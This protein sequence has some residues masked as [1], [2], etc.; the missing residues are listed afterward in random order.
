MHSNTQIHI[1]QD[2]MIGA[3]HAHLHPFANQSHVHIGQDSTIGVINSGGDLA[4]FM[5]NLLQSR[6]ALPDLLGAAIGV[7]IDCYDSAR[8]AGIVADLGGAFSQALADRP[9]SRIGLDVL[10]CMN[11]TDADAVSEQLSFLATAVHRLREA[12]FRWSLP[13]KSAAPAPLAV[14]VVSMPERVTSV[15]IERDPVSLSIV[16]STQIERD[17]IP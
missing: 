2:S 7:L 5:N 8:K 3:G 4:E 14:A 10:Q 11:G 15:N 1:G 16:G 12:G 17:K 13:A 6:K 9:T